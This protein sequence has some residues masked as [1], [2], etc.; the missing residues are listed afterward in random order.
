MTQVEDRVGDEREKAGKSSGALGSWE[1]APLGEGGA[2]VH[3]HTQDG[4]EPREASA[5]K[6]ETISLRE[7]GK[8]TGSVRRKLVNSWVAIDRRG[9][10]DLARPKKE[11][12]ILVALHFYLFVLLYF[13]DLIYSWSINFFLKFLL[14]LERE[15]GEGR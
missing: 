11:E 3:L 13:C 9:E 12:I 4:L 5:Q 10:A 1:R 7:P 6:Q 8:C 15:G 2:E 14:I